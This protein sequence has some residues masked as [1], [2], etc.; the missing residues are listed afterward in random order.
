MLSRKGFALLLLCLVFPAG[1]ESWWWRRRRRRRSPAPAPAPQPARDCTV[2]QWSSW[3]SCS[4]RCGNSGTSYRDRTKLT[5]EAHG[6]RCPYHL[7]ETEACNRGNC[8]NGGT[9]R[10]G[11]CSCRSGYGGTCCGNGKHEPSPCFSV[12]LLY[13]LFQTVW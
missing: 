13:A 1:S 7:H 2:S 9:P 4:H 10:S 12:G 8:Q 5:Q 11:Y 3:S 6:G